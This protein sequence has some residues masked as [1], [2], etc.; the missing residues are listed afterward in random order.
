MSTP[1]APP[2]AQDPTPGAL[3]RTD[4]EPA[5]VV[6]QAGLLFQV[7]RTDEALRLLKTHGVPVD[8]VERVLLRKGERRKR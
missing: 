1:T 4:R 3:G 2:P 5:I 7:G 8:V 6:E